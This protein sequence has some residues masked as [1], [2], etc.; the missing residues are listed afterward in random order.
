GYCSGVGGE[1]C[2]GI[3]WRSATDVT[4]PKAAEALRL[5]S[6]D[7]FKLRVIDD[8]IPEPLGAAHR[9]PHE[10][11]RILQKYLTRYLRELRSKTAEELL[12]SRYQKFRRMGV[13]E[14]I[15]GPIEAP[16]P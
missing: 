7:L 13:F 14:E 4:K 16:A 2:A 5:T 11:G 6:R 10:M 8:I 12:E 3:L 9:E 1:G 15:A